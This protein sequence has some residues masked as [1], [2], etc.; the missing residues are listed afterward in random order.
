MPK[1]RKGKLEKL[2]ALRVR[3]RELYA[4]N[5]SMPDIAKELHK[6]YSWA[7]SVIK[8]QYKDI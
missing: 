3:A 8:G 2:Q 6:S 1:L 5:Y 7:F 4:N